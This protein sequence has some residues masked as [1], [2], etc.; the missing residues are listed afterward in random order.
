[1][2]GCQAIGSVRRGWRR[3]GSNRGGSI[4]RAVTFSSKVSGAE[5]HEVY[6]SIRSRRF[7]SAFAGETS[8]IATSSAPH[9]CMVIRAAHGKISQAACGNPT[10]GDQPAFTAAS[11]AN[12]PS[13]PQSGEGYENE[14]FRPRRS[15]REAFAW[16]SCAGRRDGTARGLRVGAVVGRRILSATATAE[17]GAGGGLFHADAT[18]ASCPLHDS[19]SGYYG[20]DRAEPD[21]LQL[22][23]RDASAAGR[24][25]GNP[26]AASDPRP[27]VGARLL[28][29]EQQPVSMDRRPLGGPAARGS[30]V[31]PAALAAGG[32][33]VALFR[34]LLGLTSDRLEPT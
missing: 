31:G 4:A 25:A 3:F 19:G 33:V 17:L 15:S 28:E 26:H 10:A 1:M 13:Y 16:S 18:R 34:R 29:L 27:R 20:R 21:R 14:Y 30:R 22:D 11:G 24:P 2:R 5:S 12:Q 7:R 32:N 8:G 6:P 23:R 9:P